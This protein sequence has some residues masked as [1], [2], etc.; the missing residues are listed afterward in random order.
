MRLLLRLCKA[1]VRT[2]GNAVFHLHFV[3]QGDPQLIFPKVEVE[4]GLTSHQTHYRSYQETN[5]TSFTMLEATT[6]DN[7]P[8]LVCTIFCNATETV[9]L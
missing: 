6:T 9:S 7:G 3:D 5:E 1:V 2:Q 8:T 4:Q